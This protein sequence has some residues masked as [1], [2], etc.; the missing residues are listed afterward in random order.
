MGIVEK[1]IRARGALWDCMPGEIPDFMAFRLTRAQTEELFR[2]SHVE[3][4][5]GRER[6]F[7]GIPIIIIGE[8]PAEP[9]SYIWP[10]AIKSAAA[11]V[12]FWESPLVHP[13]E[14][15]VNEVRGGEVVSVR[16]DLRGVIA[17]SI[18]EL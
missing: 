14:V 15:P 9:A 13:W 1:M 17:A 12:E 3:M 11:V 10:E 7:M 18:R 8:S 2:G 5:S 16:W 4:Q 6:R